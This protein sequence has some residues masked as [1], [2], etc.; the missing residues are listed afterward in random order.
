ME[1]EEILVAPGGELVEIVEVPQGAEAVGMPQLDFS[2]YPNQIFWLIV[3]LVAIYLILSRVA[4][5]RIGAVLAER[6]GSITNDIASAEELKLKAHQSE[7]AYDKALAD[8][9]AEAGRIVA[10]NKAEM[11]AQIQAAMERADADI[12]E[13]SAESEARINEIRAGAMDA[14]QEVARDTA[15][16]IVAA[17]GGRDDTAQVHAAV[18]DR[19]KGAER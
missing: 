18:D 14:V 5:P 19:L 10:E 15:I 9:R 6:Q 4:L 3:A 8:A 2:T 11:Q 7:A 1:T 13:Q 17:F 12:A 16:A